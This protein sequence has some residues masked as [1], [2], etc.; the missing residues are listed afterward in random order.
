MKVGPG[1]EDDNEKVDA[2]APESATLFAILPRPEMFANGR[3]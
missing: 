1:L 3:P 2:D